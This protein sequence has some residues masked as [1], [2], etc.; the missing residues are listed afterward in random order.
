[1]ACLAAGTAE[2]E[3]PERAAQNHAGLARHT[4]DPIGREVEPTFAS[5][6]LASRTHRPGFN[7]CVVADIDS[8]GHEQPGD[9][10]APTP[11]LMG[12]GTTCPRLTDIHVM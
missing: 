12:G 1:M 5:R 6:I 11:L 9:V 7:V 4:T 2:R 10:S 8:I 3:H